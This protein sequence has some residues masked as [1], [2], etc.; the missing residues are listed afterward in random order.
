MARLNLS[1]FMDQKKRR[2]MPDGEEE[3]GTDRFI[4]DE[5]DG[6]EKEGNDRFD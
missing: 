3:E 6:E 2:M 5:P 4:E 1:L